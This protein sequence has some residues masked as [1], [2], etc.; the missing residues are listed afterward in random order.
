MDRLP[1]AAR[2]PGRAVRMVPQPVDKG[3][4]LATVVGSPQCGRLGARPHGPGARLGVR[5]QLPDR[6]HRSVR[7]GRE[8][9]RSTV[10]LVPR[11]AVV[12]AVENRRPPVLAARAD[13]QPRRAAASIDGAGGNLLHEEMRIAEIPASSIVIAAGDP[14]ALARAN[15]EQH[16]HARSVPQP[17][18]ERRSGGVPQP[19]ILAF[20][21][22]NSAAVIVPESRSAASLVSSSA[23]LWPEVPAA[24]R[25]YARISSSRRW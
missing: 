20:C 3:E 15:H 16:R 21:C 8:P 23:V 6:L 9:D 1:A 25:T 14:Q 5:R 2:F 17:A 4:G 7:F 11:A 24:S 13:E 12:I 10:G 19:R 22:S 18:R